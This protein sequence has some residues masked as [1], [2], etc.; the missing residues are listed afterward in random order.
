MHRK[1]EGCEG[2]ITAK[3]PKQDLQA[4]RLQE[5]LSIV[6][7]YAGHRCDNAAP[8]AAQRIICTTICLMQNCAGL[9][10]EALSISFR[11]YFLPVSLLI[12]AES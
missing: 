5:E 8:L 10:T 2:R 3:T 1:G 4:F 12:H 6:P 9:F 7:I 11:M